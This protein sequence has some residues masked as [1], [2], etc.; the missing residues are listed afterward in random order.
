MAQNKGANVRYRAIDKCLS[1]K[2]GRYSWEDL[3]RACE[4]NLIGNRAYLG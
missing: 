2:H 1:A 3:Q 4:I